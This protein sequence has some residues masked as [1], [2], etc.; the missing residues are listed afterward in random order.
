MAI[1]DATKYR[2]MHRAV[3]IESLLSALTNQRSYMLALANTDLT[4]Y[5]LNAL[6]MIYNEN[7]ALVNLLGVEVPS[8]STLVKRHNEIVYLEKLY[9]SPDEESEGT[10]QT[11]Q[12]IT[13]ISRVASPEIRGD[14]A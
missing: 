4:P 9:N 7:E 11:T 3:S 6:S 5:Q 10:G 8:L 1:V 13:G 2:R 12:E 14:E